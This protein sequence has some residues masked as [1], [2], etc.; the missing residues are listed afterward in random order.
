MG[1]STFRF[2]PR[3]T[4]NRGWAPAG[5]GPLVGAGMARG[6]GG[7]AGEVRLGKVGEQGGILIVGVAERTLDRHWDTTSNVRVNFG[8]ESPSGAGPGGLLPEPD[9]ACQPRFV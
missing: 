1:Y 4:T 8:S 2:W 6:G 5:R 9:T 3:W 7:D